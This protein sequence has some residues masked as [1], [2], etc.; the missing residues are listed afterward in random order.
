M[1]LRPDEIAALAEARHGS[2]H[3]LLGLHPVGRGCVA[4]ALLPGADACQLLDPATGRSHPMERIHPDGLFEVALPDV[5]AFP[6]RLRETRGGVVRELDDP[7]RF[8]PS[9][10]PQDLHFL[11]IGDDHR[12]HE[13][14]GGHPRRLEGV[15]G[16]AFTVWAP[17]ARRVSVV[18]D[19]NRWD[20]RAHPM[21][22]LGA[23]GVWELFIPGLG[24]GNGIAG[25]RICGSFPGARRRGLDAGRSCQGRG[26]GLRCNRLSGRSLLRL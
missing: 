18:G 13:K 6:H 16:V 5:P 8:L 25:G 4:R 19:F 3:D 1:R 9:L 26:L 20:G 10:G 17:H 2:P 15:D 24:P 23:S 22:L 11:A 14:L 12:I 7:Y 21:R